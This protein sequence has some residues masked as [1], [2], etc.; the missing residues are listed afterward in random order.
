MFHF[1]PPEMVTNSPE[2]RAAPRRLHPEFP[3]PAPGFL[4]SALGSLHICPYMSPASRRS[5]TV[6]P[7]GRTMSSNRFPAALGGWSRCSACVLMR[8]F[9]GTRGLTLHRGPLTSIRTDYVFFYVTY[10]LSKLFK[11]L[12]ILK[13]VIGSVHFCAM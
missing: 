2:G 7:G 12:V 5:T 10:L 4:G 3:A 6:P 1:F 11:R 13:S 8:D 9:L